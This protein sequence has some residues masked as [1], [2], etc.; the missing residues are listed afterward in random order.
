MAK[1]VSILVVINLAVNNSFKK[2]YSCQSVL[3][4]AISESKQGTSDFLHH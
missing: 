1:H 3:S 2:V 4:E